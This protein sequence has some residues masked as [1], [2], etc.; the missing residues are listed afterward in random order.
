MLPVV[1][2]RYSCDDNGIKSCT[3][4]FADDSC[5]P[6]MGPMACGIGNIYVN[7]VLEQVVKFPTYSPGA[8]YCLSVVVHNGRILRTGG[9]SVP[10]KS[11][12]RSLLSTIA[13]LL[14]DVF[15]FVWVDTDACWLLNVMITNNI[16]RHDLG[17]KT[18]F[19]DKDILR[20]TGVKK[21]D[22]PRHL[23]LG[24]DEKRHHSNGRDMIHCETQAARHETSK[25]LRIRSRQNCEAIKVFEI[26]KVQLSKHII[27]VKQ[28]AQEQTFYCTVSKQTANKWAECLVA[29]F[30]QEIPVFQR[31]KN[32]YQRLTQTQSRDTRH[33]ETR[34]LET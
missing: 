15:V 14:H 23:E 28:Q 30:Q 12:E 21:P 34:I 27:A 5:F 26:A 24:W 19:R 22:E 6:I 3:S 33:D 13:L 8:S 25:T 17:V 9:I 32:I 4:G 10:H 7:V 31:R 16:S 18:F 2:T 29:F 11:R 1:L 20:D